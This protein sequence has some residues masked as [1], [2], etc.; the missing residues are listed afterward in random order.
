MYSEE[1]NGVAN[2]Q[3]GYVDDEPVE[4]DAQEE[5]QEEED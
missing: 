5:D 2:D 3:L 1:E 4:D